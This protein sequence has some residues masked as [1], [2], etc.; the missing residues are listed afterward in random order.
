MPEVSVSAVGDKL[1]AAIDAQHKVQQAARDAAAAAKQPAP[2]PSSG[3]A[4]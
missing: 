2:A 4:K 1:R 3:P